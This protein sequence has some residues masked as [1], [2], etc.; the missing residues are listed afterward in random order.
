LC[1][2]AAGFALSPPPGTPLTNTASISYST[3]NGTPLPIAFETATIT[4]AG[5][6]LLHLEKTVDS[7]PVAAGASTTYTIRCTNSGNAAATAVQVIDTLPANVTFLSAAEGGIYSPENHSVTWSLGV[8]PAGQE[9]LVTVTVKV[10]EGLAVGTPLINQASVACAE[11][12]GGNIALTT[13]IGFSANTVLVKTATPPVTMPNGIITYALSYHNA[14]NAAAQKVHVADQVPT[15][16]AYVPG[17]ATAGAVLAGNVLSWELG[18]LPPGSSGEVSFQVRVSP[19]AITGQAISNTAS[20]ISGSLAKNSNTVTTPVSSLAAIQLIKSAPATVLAG[21]PLTYELRVGNTGTVPLT[22]V[23]LTDTIPEGTTFVSADSGGLFSAGSGTVAW[24]IGTMAPGQQQMVTLTVLVGAKLADGFLVKNS[25]SVTAAEAPSQ[26]STT[27]T[28]VLARTPGEVGFF[29]SS[30]K[31]A[32]GYLGGDFIYLQVTDLDQNVD[33]AVAE[34]I[35]VVLKD[36]NSGDTETFILTETGPNTG[37]FRSIAIPTSLDPKQS[38]DGKLTVTPDSQVQATYTDPLDPSPVS[39]ALALIDPLGIVF[40]SV[41]GVPVAGA[42]VTL[43]NWDGTANA[44]D[45]SSLPDLPPG[46]VNPA[47]P[48]GVDGKFAFPLVQAGDYCYQVTLPPGHQFPSKVPD[49]D[50]PPGYTVGNG[51]R[52]DKFTLSIGDPPLIRDIPVD[53]PAGGLNMTKSADKT[54]AAVGDI[55]AYGLKLTN[56]GEAPVSSL[57]LR[58]TMPHGILYLPGTSRLNG[59]P[60]PDPA[61]RGGKHLEWI[62]PSLG[63]GKSLEITYRAVVGPDSPRGDGV[64]T[65][66]A[67]G[68]SLGEAITSNRA[69]VKVKISEGVFTAK[70]T[71]IGKVFLDR[72]GDRV[73]NQPDSAMGA[74]PSGEAGIANVAIYLED[75]TRV[76]TDNQGKFS[77]LGVIP[78]THVLRVDETTLPKGMSLTPLSNRFLG[79]GAS[80]FIDMHPSGLVQADFAAMMKRSEATSPVTAPPLAAATLKGL[81]TNQGAVSPQADLPAAVPS[82]S[83]PSQS[84]T[85]PTGT[86]ASRVWEQEIKE[87]TPDLE[88]LTPNDGSVLIRDRIRVVLK[89]PFGTE[90]TLLLNGTPVGAKQIGRKIDYEQ[91][92]VTIFEYIDIAL[93]AGEANLLKAEVRDPFGI[94]RG[95]RSITVS[96]TGAPERITIRTDKA[97]VPADGTSVIRVDVSFRDRNDR[98][99]PYAAFANVSVSAGEIVEKDADPNQEEFQLMIREGVG[100]FTLRAPRE[101]GEAIIVAGLDGRQESTK[102]FFTPNLRSLFLVGMGEAT[103]GHGRGTG[104]YGL[105]KDNSW[106]DNGT[107]G[108]A[109]GAFFLKGKMYEDFLL[110]AAFDSDK[111]KRNDL[112]RQNDTALDGE[113]KYPLYGDESKTGYEALSTGKAYL[114]IEKNRSSLLYGDFRTDLNDTRLAAYNRSFTGLKYDLTVEDFK[115]RS[116][117]SYSDQTQ[118]MDIIAGKGIS[119]YYYLTRRPVIDGSE[120]VVIETRDR[121]RPDTVVSRELKARGSDYEIDYDL[122]AILFKEPIPSHNGE[123]NPLYIVVSYESKTFG[124][125]YYVYG[126]RGALKPFSWLEVGATGVVEEKALGKGMLTGADATISLPAKTAVKVEYAETKSVFDEAGVFDWRFGDAWSLTMESEP[127]DMLKISG[128]YRTV[129][130]Y[131]QNMSAVDSPRGT[132]KYGFDALYEFPAQTRVT[133]RFFNEE[134][135]LNNMRHRLASIGVQSK[136]QKTKLSAA[137]TNESSTDSYIPLTDPNN[138]SPFDISQ[139]TPH[140][141]TDLKVGMETEIMPD[142]SL[143]LSHKQNLSRDNYHMSQAG[144]N[145]LLNSRNRLYLREEYQKYEERTETRTLLGVETQLI[146]NTVAF[147]EYR[148]ADGADGARNQNVI[149]LRNKFFL[150][151]HVTGNVSAEYLRTISG[152]QRN[153]EPDAFAGSLGMEYLASET[154]KLTGRLEHRR[155]LIA[156]GRDSYLAE[157][158]VVHKLHPDY[159]LLFRERYFTE[160]SGTGGEHTTSRTLLGVAYRPRFTNH[161]NAL[162]KMEYKHESNATTTPSFREDAWILSGEG[163]WTVTPRL[164]LTGKYAGKFVN[165]ESF[166]SYTDLYALNLLH[167]LTDRWDIGAEYRL[168]TSH[169]VNSC[170]QGGALEIG[171]RVIKNLWI[172]AG[173]SFDRFDADLNGDSYQGQGPYVKIRVKFDE[174]S[175][176]G[177]E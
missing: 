22:G 2:S 97:E 28:S 8:I 16:T 62:A 157:A 106:F 53:P 107:Y 20:V 130:D 69:K 25:A 111:E 59:L 11:G 108:G 116:F 160:E 79:D 136:F 156:T 55:I 48:T 114:K 154:S 163:S 84:T 60:F 63:A 162:G 23:V 173:Y 81:P 159:S 170:Y 150:A 123:F 12:V 92:Q 36:L 40:D 93:N 175:L 98:I 15:G 171:Y 24:N 75:G 65:V 129:A 14:G 58:D 57:T 9:R 131:F 3:D 144:L 113:D 158:G 54:A 115:L 73:Q 104:D 117:V 146:K 164:R 101:T 134:D 89:A 29:D 26:T 122:G 46:Q 126:G 155:E 151:E 141:L 1:G 82:P 125:K 70:G 110:T 41:T 149:G 68:V 66:F 5:A 135:D 6:P 56:T 18:D 127:V 133:G 17:S 51:S 80:Q 13:T 109:R 165:D 143:T 166:S 177:P 61:I 176:P 100:Q 99:V 142:L 94:V 42:V 27:T 72:N 86:M 140:E 112:F 31:P 174:K 78:G 137:I 7:D 64:N 10:A 77:I 33:P 95:T 21:T 87:M 124:E 67:S 38:G 19:L 91:G 47:P 121:I 90:P 161:F 35:T 105:L 148:L 74:P 172:A 153:T 37:M 50:L 138:R 32:Y 128:Y 71:I 120:R 88:F 152:S 145:Y 119:G 118:V 103:I 34:T 96:A 167:D 76:L 168:L 49:K 45:L 85:P 139:D 43:R 30:W 44:C 83:P 169:A 147:N 39:T 132:T 4:L 52:G 102:V